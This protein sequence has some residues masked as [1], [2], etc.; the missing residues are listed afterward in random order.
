M[1]IVLNCIVVDDEFM[2]RKIVEDNISHFPYL[3]LIASCKNVFE[4]MDFLDKGNVDLIFLDIQ[5]PG[6]TGTTFLGSLLNKPMTIFIT[7]YPQYALQ[8]FELD[9]LDYLVKPISLERFTK[10]V[11]KAYDLKKLNAKA[12]QESEPSSPDS[13]NFI[14]VYVEY[15]LVKVDKREILFIEGMKD[16]VKIFLANGKKRVI[17]KLSLTKI[18]D[19]LESENFM[20]VHKSYIAAIDKIEAIR[21]QNLYLEEHQIPVS[22][23]KMEELI[24]RMH[25][26]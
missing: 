21:N 6:L 1:D 3:N 22:S 20:R 12:E 14:F 8:G 16:Y 26:Q 2:A 11:K 19:K 18:L 7:A 23:T 13:G 17:T 10:A 25:Q 5:M 4:A 9:V 24:G 15:S